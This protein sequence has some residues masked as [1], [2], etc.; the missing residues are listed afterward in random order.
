MKAF[1]VDHN[2]A[3]KMALLRDDIQL[4]ILA[5]LTVFFCL[6]T[7]ALVG[8]DLLFGIPLKA[9]CA[10]TEAPAWAS[11]TLGPK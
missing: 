1:W 5:A 3:H 8:S 4:S 11:P 6:A 7:I 2:V 9:R 10:A